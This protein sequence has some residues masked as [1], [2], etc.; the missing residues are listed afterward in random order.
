MKADMSEQEK[1]IM[2]YLEHNYCG[3][4]MMKNESC[5]IRIARAIAAFKADPEVSSFVVFTE[6]F[7]TEEGIFI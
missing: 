5:Q 6:K 7:I 1:E 4:K 3:A 2:K